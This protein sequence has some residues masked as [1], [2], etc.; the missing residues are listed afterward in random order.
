MRL[1]LLL[2]VLLGALESASGADTIVGVGNYVTMGAAVFNQFPNVAPVRVCAIQ[3]VMVPTATFE[4]RNRLIPT[5]TKGTTFALKA[6]VGDD[7]LPI[8]KK[9][10]AI[11]VQPTSWVDAGTTFSFEKPFSELS[12]TVS[13]NM[14]IRD[15]VLACSHDEADQV[16]A[17][18]LSLRREYWHDLFFKNGVS[19]RACDPKDEGVRL[20]TKADYVFAIP[21][22]AMHDGVT[23][24][25]RSPL[26]ASRSSE[27]P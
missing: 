11:A 5:E 15:V 21:L 23:S 4:T 22:A 12:F 14:C 10:M 8:S 18:R 16:K 19:R 25:R 20:A 6:S 26:C 2:G 1:L 24:A 9:I 3:L 27:R 17:L 13:N 7:V